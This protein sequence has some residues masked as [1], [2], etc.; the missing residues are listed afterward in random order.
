MSQYNEL[1]KLIN[2]QEKEINGLKTQLKKKQN[3]PGAGGPSK[4]HEDNWNK[5]T[6]I[7]FMNGNNPYHDVT[8]EQLATVIINTIY[9]DADAEDYAEEAL[10]WAKENGISDASRPAH[11]TTRQQ[12]ITIVKRSFDKAAYLPSWMYDDIAASFDGI[13]QYLTKPD[14]WKKD[15]EN[16]DVTVPE[17]LGMFMLAFLNKENAVEDE[18]EEPDTEHDESEDQEE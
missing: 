14:R 11:L 6:K 12:L 7:G 13:G 17:L 16:H 8:R 1:K 3:T 2:A 4:A 15:I 10:K 5:A 18:A 9:N